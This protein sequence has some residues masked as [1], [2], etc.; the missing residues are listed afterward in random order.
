MNSSRIIINIRDGVSEAEALAAVTRVVEEGRISRQADRDTY[1]MATVTGSEIL[2][3]AEC[4]P[5]G[6]DRFYVRRQAQHVE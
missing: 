1:C 5:T 3:F 4:T 2:V 6:T